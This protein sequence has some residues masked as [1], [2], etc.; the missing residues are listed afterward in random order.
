MRRFCI[1]RLCADS[2]DAQS[3]FHQR[4]QHDFNRPSRRARDATVYV[5]DL[6]R[7]FAL[8]RGDGTALHVTGSLGENR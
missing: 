7:C 6:A 3:L 4:K 2:S 5:A 1:E 8:W